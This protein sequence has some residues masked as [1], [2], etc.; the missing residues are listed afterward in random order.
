VAAGCDLVAF[1][2]AQS[3]DGRLV[4]VEAVI[5]AA[6]QGGALT[7]CDTTQAAGWMDVDASRFDVTVCSA[8]KWL[9]APRG[10]AF[11][12]VRPGMLDRIRPVNAGWYAGESVWG[13]CY[14][15]EMD[16]AP[17]ARRFDVSPAWLSWV[18]AVPS[19]E[20]FTALTCAERAH[21]SMLADALRARLGLPPQQRPVVSLPDA[22]GA[23][24]Q[25]LTLAGCTVAGRAGLVRIA[26]H[27]WNDDED[28]ARVGDA[29]ALAGSVPLLR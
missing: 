29:L 25:Q 23:I 14:G 13:S 3:A 9:C 22:D 4:D 17:D 27:L 7:F 1:S 26:F 28:V 21:G 20:L 8:Y 2:L 24:A 10:S 6:R 15:P 18:G 5:E 19:L 11:T 12:T 16:L